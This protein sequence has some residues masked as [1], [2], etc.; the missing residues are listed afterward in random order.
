[1]TKHQPRSIL[2]RDET[3]WKAVY[4][5]FHAIAKNGADDVFALFGT[6]PRGSLKAIAA[7][8]AAGGQ[9]P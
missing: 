7:I 5:N 1:M 6:D 9:S 8:D 4:N 2:D 3:S